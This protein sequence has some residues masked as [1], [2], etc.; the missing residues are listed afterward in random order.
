MGMKATAAKLEMPPQFTVG[1]FVR[2]LTFMKN[3]S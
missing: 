1:G 2:K 3:K